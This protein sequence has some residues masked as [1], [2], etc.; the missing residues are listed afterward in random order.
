[1]NIFLENTEEDSIA[2][3]QKVALNQLE[4]SSLRNYGNLCF[5]FDFIN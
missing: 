1:M 4:L 2:P 3:K 5:F